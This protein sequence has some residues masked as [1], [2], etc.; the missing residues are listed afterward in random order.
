[1]DGGGKCHTES[2]RHKG[3]PKGGGMGHAETQRRGDA[4]EDKRE[5]SHRGTEAQRKTKGGGKGHAK[6]QRRKGIGKKTGNGL[7]FGGSSL[8]LSAFA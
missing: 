8:R 7:W 1:M 6:T 5:G 4:E 3:K 2:Q